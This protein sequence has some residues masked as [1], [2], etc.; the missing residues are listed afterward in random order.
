VSLK[1]ARNLIGAFGIAARR[2]DQYRRTIAC[3]K[4]MPRAKKRVS[5]RRVEIAQGIVSIV[6]VLNQEP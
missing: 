1:Q 2:V 4:F 6:G 5:D 3:R